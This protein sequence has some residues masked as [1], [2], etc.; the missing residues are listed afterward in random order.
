MMSAR[1]I[2]VLVVAVMLAAEASSQIV[3][4]RTYF[5]I[6]R[7]VPVEI[8]RP[9]GAEGALSVRLL[10]ADNA[11]LAEAAC[12]E[13]PTDIASKFEGFW[14]D[15]ATRASVRYAQLYAG[16][17]PVGPA[18]VL[19]PMLTPE[20]AYLY[21]APGQRPEVR[22]R[23]GQRAVSGLRA[24]VEQHT[25]METS[26][27]EIRFRMRPDM[28]PNTVWNFLS[29]ADG[30]YYTDVIFHR[31]IGGGNGRPPFVVQAGDPRGE[32]VGGPGY[33]IDLERSSLPHTFGVLS[34]ARSSDPN[35]AGSQVFICLSRAGTQG[36][37]GDYTSFAEAVGGAEAILAIESVETGMNDRPADPPVI[38]RVRLVD[39]PARG[40]GPGVIKRPE[41]AP[42][43]R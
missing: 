24:Y 3:P 16:E 36:L 17:T 31:I 6:N 29:L 7:P 28:A 25:I 19:Q 23:S 26:A 32:G 35:S 42:A 8:S 14:S 37:D 38:E 22:W 20:Q 5:G 9:D 30:G 34:M 21:Q 33:F 2:G 4:S 13:G 40:K 41:S 27:G 1:V 43:G 39:A 18:L 15:E 12:E 11:K 10:T